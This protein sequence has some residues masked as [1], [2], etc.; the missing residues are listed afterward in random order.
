M[1]PEASNGLQLFPPLREAEPRILFARAVLETRP[2]GSQFTA[3]GGWGVAE[4]AER[5]RASGPDGSAQRCVAGPRAGGGAR[6]GMELQPE[7]WG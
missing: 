2:L 5:E 3:P 4:L 7:A 1:S 6:G